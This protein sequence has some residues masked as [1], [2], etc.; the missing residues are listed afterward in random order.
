MSL[1]S[2]LH[3]HELKLDL[4]ESRKQG[5]LEEAE[6]PKPE[7]RK[8]TMTVSKLTA[9]SGPIKLASRCVRI[10]IRTSNI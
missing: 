10:L 6:E 8:R 5:A 4:A 1:R 3:D 7:P 9:R 2:Q